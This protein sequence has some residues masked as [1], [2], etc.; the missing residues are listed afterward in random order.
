MPNHRHLHLMPL[1]AARLM[2]APALLTPPA[3]LTAPALLLAAALFTTQALF[4]TPAH[5]QTFTRVTDPANPVVN[6]AYQSGGGCWIDLVGDGYLDLFVANGNLSNE[7]NALYRNNRA[8]GFV[9]AT[10][11]NVRTDG[12]SSIG[13]TIGDYDNDGLVDL[14]V[15]NRNFWKNFLYR[16]LGDTLFENVTAVPPVTDSGNS[17]SS[18]WIDIDNDGD[19]DLYVVNF[20]GADFLYLNGGGPSFSFARLDT[21]ALTAGA[22]FSIPGAWADYNND[23]RSDLFIGNAGA[24]HDYLYANHGN[25][26]FTRTVLADGGATLGASWG[27][28]DNDGDL[29]LVVPHLLNQKCKLYRN[30]GAPLFTM[31]PVDTGIVSNATGSWVGS[32][33]GDW[34]NDGDLDLYVANDGQA[35]GLYRNN[36]APGFGFTRMTTG[37]VATDTGY[38]FGAV[39]G[40]YDR[41]GQL[42]LFVANRLGE[43]NRLYHNLGNPNHWLTIRA[44]GTVSNRS[45]IGARIR[46]YARV[47]GIDICQMREVTGQTGYNS[48]NLD[49]HFGLADAAFADSVVIDWPSGVRD[50]WH[51]VAG[52]RWMRLEEGGATA[53]APTPPARG[54][55]SIELGAPQPNPVR[56]LTAISFRLAAP[57]AVRL[58]LFDVRGRLV[59]TLLAKQ[60]EAGDHRFL[61]RRDPLTAAGVYFLRLAAGDA[62]RSERIVLAR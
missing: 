3:L 13:A 1:L 37:P 36:G 12:G 42:D 33:W 61:Y 17:N 44:I 28:Y 26:H 43:F 45:A 4:P 7:P 53:I 50:T 48:Q 55:S 15:T 29:D 31:T 27:D 21:T 18:S 34:D 9:R 59:T 10:T 11:G 40:D 24:Q 49:Q 52:D 23:G 2:A 57:A 41:D 39:W 6:E 38:N 19:L 60:L 35:G 46:L 51:G 16:G 58:A 32:S 20:Q 5:A 8:G 54:E 62:V 30:S 14:F 22:E 25:Y 47:N 56:D